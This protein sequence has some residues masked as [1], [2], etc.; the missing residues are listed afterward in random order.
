M[1]QFRVI[2]YS[3]CQLRYLHI[4]FAVIA[5]IYLNAYYQRQKLTKHRANFFTL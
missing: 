1:Q 5:R 3:D 2:Y 4:N